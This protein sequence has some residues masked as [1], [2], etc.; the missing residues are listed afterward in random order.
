MLCCACCEVCNV[1]AGREVTYNCTPP[2]HDT[3]REARCSFH[4]DPRF[5]MGVLKPQ[6]RD[7]VCS[8][9]LR[10]TAYPLAEYDRI[11]PIFGL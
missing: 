5:E 1:Y 4:R 11:D 8:H 9:V 3:I 2:V 6:S 10:F 7:F